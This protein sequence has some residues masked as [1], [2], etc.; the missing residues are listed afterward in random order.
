M[1]GDDMVPSGYRRRSILKSLLLGSAACGSGLLSMTLDP[2]CAEACSRILWKNSLGTYVGRGEDWFS[3]A[4]TDLWVLPRGMERAGA[5]ADNP[6]KWT[7]QYGS[8][9][10][11]M[12]DHVS[13][14]GMN[15]R[16]FS[17]HVLWLSDTKVAPRD[18]KLPAISISQWMQWYL[19]SF[20]TV[21]EAA[22]ASR[23]LPFQ[24][25]MAMDHNGTKGLFHIAV[26]DVSGDSAIFEM[27][28][29]EM[30]IYHD[31]RYVVMTN[32]PTYD[33]Q[34]KVVSQYVGFGG[35]KPLP[36]TSEPSDRLVRG[37]YY[38]TNL[39]DPANEREAVAS[40]LSVMRNVGIP[41]ESP[42]AHR[43]STHPEA[44]PALTR[45]IFRLIMNLDERVVFFDRVLSPTVFWVRLDGFDFKKGAKVK[46]L[47]TNGN[48]LAYD[49][50]GKFKPAK[51]FT[52]IS[53]TEDTLGGP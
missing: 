36:G 20:A 51:M 21:K 53:G 15:E 11:V 3:D 29:G 43:Q 39:P 42:S 48:D 41:Y 28:D 13:M 10:V 38:A 19:D 27:I 34:L 46:K 14:S 17:A 16:G 18:P 30:K 1:H 5:V 49:A 32:E 40:L 26:E 22:E 31:R 44:T 4:P 2:Q 24:I 52:F 7:S 6:Y 45:T 8:L 50:T 47:P 12:D 37:A 33:Q 23:N 35:D 25:R 9:V